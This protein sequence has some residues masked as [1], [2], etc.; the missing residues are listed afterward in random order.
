MNKRPGMTHF[1]HAIEAVSLAVLFEI[2]IMFM[3]FNV[4]ALLWS[5]YEFVNIRLQ[6]YKLIRVQ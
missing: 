6:G 5:R 2:K 3:L 1:L 4:K